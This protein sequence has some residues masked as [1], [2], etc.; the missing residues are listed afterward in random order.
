[1]PQ[2][3]IGGVILNKLVRKDPSKKV[4]SDSRPE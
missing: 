1:M 4:P 3:E 2:R